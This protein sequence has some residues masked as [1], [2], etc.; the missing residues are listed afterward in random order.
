[1]RDCLLMRGTT[2]RRVA[3]VVAL[4]LAGCA[5]IKPD[6]RRPEAE[7]PAGWAAAQGQ[8]SATAGAA[9]WKIFGDAELDRL[10]EE[11]LAHNA[12]LA[13]AVARVD[14]ARA[15][16]GIAR[17]DQLPVVD[18]Q[19]DRSR[20]RTSEV[21]ALPL[22]PGFPRDVNDYRAALNVSYELDLW[23]RLRNLSAAAR[24]DLL[25]S[26]AA[27][28]TVRIT[29]AADVA[30]AYFALRA[31]DEQIATVQRS[32][33]ARG[34][35][36]ALQKKRLE[37]G[38]ISELDYR[39]VEAEAAAAR[40]QLPALERQ[41]SAQENALAVLLG[42]SPRAIYEGT[43]VGAAAAGVGPAA[44]VVPSG[45]PSELLLRRPD[46]VEAEQTLIASNAR[47]AAA[48]A[49]L[50]PSI[51]LTGYLGSASAALSDLFTGPAGIWRLAAGLAQPIYAGGRLKEGIAAAEAR[52]RQA[53]AQYQQAVQ[54]AFKD[55]R[56]ALV[57]QAKLREQL[58]AESQRAAALRQALRLARLRYDNGM[59]SQLEV[60][61]AERNLLAAEQNRIDALRA[62]RAAIADLFKAL[63]GGWD[64]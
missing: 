25:G 45:M 48:R 4:S 26:E 50:F 27:R 51:V 49:E 39:Q 59:T 29:L 63:G 28:E 16:V 52:E 6:Y 64:A 35:T 31:F 24:A 60:L 22:P 15:Q 9:W 8:A 56:N 61:D 19:F 1:M 14:E 3:L 5:G 43:V 32:L 46:I 57:A 34:E 2:S 42:R 13:L 18:A 55:V 37:Y 38:D 30:Q 7:L 20:T 23:G 11:A 10:V 54:N 44:L 62:Q 17:A 53:L 58:D 36:L 33:D 12:D 21:V 40:A 47:I 41:R